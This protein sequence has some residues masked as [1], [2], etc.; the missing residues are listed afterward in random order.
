MAVLLIVGILVAISLPAMLKYSNRARQAEARQHVG[1]ILGAEQVYY[2]EKEN[3]FT[4]NLDD[5]ALGLQ[6]QTPNY[7]YSIRS[8]DPQSLI[9][10]ASNERPHLKIYS[11]GVFAV[12]GGTD[13]GYVSITILCE[14]K[15]PAVELK[16]IPV[17][18][19]DSDTCPPGYQR[20]NN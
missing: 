12:P 18:P 5:L 15:L 1:A 13:S 14:S 2:M 19:L 8:P 16:Q 17:A 10:T 4:E 3:V 20:L 9:V 7:T 11:G 6:S